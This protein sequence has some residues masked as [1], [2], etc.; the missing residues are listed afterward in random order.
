[1]RYFVQLYIWDVTNNVILTSLVTIYA[2]VSGGAIVMEAG[3][4]TIQGNASF[5]RNTAYYQGSAI[6][7]IQISVEISAELQAL[8]TNFY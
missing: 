1:M 7:Q 2:D 8:A 3:A 6:I 5:D 4:L